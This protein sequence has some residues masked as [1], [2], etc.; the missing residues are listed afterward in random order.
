MKAIVVGLLLIQLGSCILW[1]GGDR[2]SHASKAKAFSD[3]KRY[4]DAISEYRLHIAE[5]LKDSR[6]PEAENPHFYE[7]LIGDI[8]LKQKK[9]EQ[10]LATFV[11]A[12]EHGV[13]LPLIS[14]RIRQ[15]ARYYRNEGNYRR[16]LEVLQQHRGLDDFQFD[17]DIDEFSKEM[18]ERE[19]LR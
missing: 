14:D 18:V 17:A 2:S 12:K 19:D 4:D 11:A 13:E 3:E 1:T 16:S 10:A 15:V 7:I 8:L 6:R 9:P 5:R